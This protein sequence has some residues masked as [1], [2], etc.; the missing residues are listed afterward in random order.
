MLF[1]LQLSVFAIFFNVYRTIEV[2]RLMESLLSNS[3]AYPDFNFLSF[4]QTRYNNM[5]SVNVFFAWIK[6]LLLTLINK[7]TMFYFHTSHR[8]FSNFL[9]EI[10]KS[11]LKNVCIGVYRS[12]PLSSTFIISAKAYLLGGY[13]TLFVRETLKNATLVTSTVMFFITLLKLQPT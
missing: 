7:L 12:F 8:K 1:S 2:S 5:I 13:S 3:E 10:L 11:Y 4:W 9:L 6:V